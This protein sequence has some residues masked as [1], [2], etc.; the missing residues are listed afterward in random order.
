[1]TSKTFTPKLPQDHALPVASARE[2]IQDIGEGM[3]G[4]FALN[5]NIPTGRLSE[6]VNLVNL[7]HSKRFPSQWN[8][9]KALVQKRPMPIFVRRACACYKSNM[10]AHN[11]QRACACY[12]SQLW[13]RILCMAKPRPDVT[14]DRQIIV[15]HLDNNLVITEKAGKVPAHICT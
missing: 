11:T 8:S 4:P 15:C 7:H 2:I 1:M 12:T 13:A 10:C 5:I 6:L 9:C 14:S 3:G